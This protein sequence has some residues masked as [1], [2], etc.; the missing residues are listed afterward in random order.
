MK[1]AASTILYVVIST[2]GVA[3]F[4]APFW[5]TAAGGAPGADAPLMTA[6]LITF[7]LITMLLDAQS[8]GLGVKQIA[9]LGVL[10]AI[11]SA[12]RFAEVALPG[13]GGFTP[14]FLLIL[15]GGFAYGPRFGFLLGALSLLASAMVTAGVGPWLPFQ[16]FTAGWMGLSA[17][18]LG[19]LDTGASVHLSRRAHATLIAFGTA[20]GFAYGAIM[21]LW[22]W[23]YTMI[24]LPSDD[25]ITVLNRYGAYYV[26]T[27]F[28]WDVYGALGNAV[29]LT[30]GAP[31]AVRAL[32][33]FRQR[34]MFRLHT[35]RT[36]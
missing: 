31:T 32:R 17:G 33:R 30:L 36:P 27:S 18:W 7:A 8:A 21:N 15:C 14:I 34:M 20:W 23:P 24:R 10:A 1:R 3:A 26:T 22:S 28:A 4:L 9:M 25:L 35:V 6:L 13:P 16:M 11:N 2:A 5:T 29:L 12:L 19:A